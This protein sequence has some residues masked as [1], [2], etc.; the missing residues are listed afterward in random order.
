LF[1]AAARVGNSVA[2]PPNLWPEIQISA[3][4]IDLH[5]AKQILC[6][7]QK[8]VSRIPLFSA[9]SIKASLDFSNRGRIFLAAGGQ[10]KLQTKI[11]FFRRFL[12]FVG[13][14]SVLWLE[15][16][17]G[18]WKFKSSAGNPRKYLNFSARA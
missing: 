16:R 15:I 4:T 14:I 17:I 13:D 18:S 10:T 5:A 8:I 9:A 6:L 1:R 7:R 2:R 12:R 11:P 3:R